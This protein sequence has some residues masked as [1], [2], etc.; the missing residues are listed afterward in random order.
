MTDVQYKELVEHNIRN[1]ELA[2]NEG[3]RI[4]KG[5]HVHNINVILHKLKPRVEVLRGKEPFAVAMEDLR[6]VTE[7]A[8]QL[9]WDLWLH[10]KGR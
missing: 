10:S 1:C 4:N 3:E 5:T 8:Q 6:E 7:L 9:S 2:I